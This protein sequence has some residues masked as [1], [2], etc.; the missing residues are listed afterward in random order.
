[1][2]LQ[3]DFYGK[4]LGSCCPNKLSSI[5]HSHYNNKDTGKSEKQRQEG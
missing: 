3:S 4:S 2:C 1:M 5:A